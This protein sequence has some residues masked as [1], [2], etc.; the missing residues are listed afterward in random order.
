M[1]S[2][3]RWW[4]RFSCCLRACSSS[5]AWLQSRT[6]DERSLVNRRTFVTGLGA[7]L[8]APRAVE[9]Q[10]GR[11]PRIGVLLPGAPEPEYERRLDAFRQGLREF[12]YIENQNIVVEYRWAQARPDHIPKL[13]AELV[14]INV[15][16]LVVDSTAVAHAAKNATSTIP[17]VMALAGDPVGT[18]LVASLARPGGNITGM[19]LMTSELGAKRLELLK[20]VAPKAVRVAVLLNP[21]NRAHTIYWKEVQVVAPRLRLELKALEVRRPADVEHALST[22]TVW[23]P[24]ALFVFDDP[25]LLPAR[26]TE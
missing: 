24:D 17:I 22:V 16:V 10:V 23:R 26:Q 19:T 20:E 3:G 2:G 5:C 25:V 15:D 9:A 12:G 4:A 21:A 1:L 14:G 8:A 7:V 6:P 11:I 13:T 18:G